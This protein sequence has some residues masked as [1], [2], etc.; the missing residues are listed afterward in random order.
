MAMTTSI[1]FVVNLR[2]LFEKGR[3]YNVIC[4]ICLNVCNHVLY[5][6]DIIRHLYRHLVMC[7]H[8]HCFQQSTCI[9]ISQFRIVLCVS[10]IDNPAL[11]L[12]ASFLNPDKL[13]TVRF[14]PAINHKI[15][16]TNSSFHAK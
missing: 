14:Y 9:I 16:E 8:H 13:L 7:S 3:C 6:R 4:S 5:F 11:R 15:F 1:F 2:F 12:N 10:N